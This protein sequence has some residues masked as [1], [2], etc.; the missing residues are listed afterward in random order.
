MKHFI[1][2]IKEVYFLSNLNLFINEITIF[3]NEL[4]DENLNVSNN[5]ST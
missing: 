4:D 1:V 5:L 3:N 2:K